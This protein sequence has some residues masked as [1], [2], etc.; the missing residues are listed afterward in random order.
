M[1]LRENI[2]NQNDFTLGLTKQLLQTECKQSNVVYSPLSIHV[3][4]SLIA[5]GSKGPTQNQLQ[6]FLKSNSTNHLNSF[7]AELVSVIFSDRSPSGGPQ[8][9]FVSGGWVD[10]CLHLKPYFKQVVETSYMAALAQVFPPR[11]ID[12]S[13]TLI[14]ANALYFKRAWTEKFNASQTKEHDFHL[15]D[16][17]I[18]KVPFMTSRK[19][20]YVR[21]FN[22]F[23]MHIF[24]REGKD[25]LPALV[26]KL[27]SESGFLDRHL[28]KQK[29]VVGDF[30]IPKFKISFGFKASNI[31]KGLSLVLPFRGGGGLT[32]MVDSPEGTG[33]KHSATSVSAGF[34]Q[35]KKCGNRLN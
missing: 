32:E 10:R 33:E 8:L 6:S 22:G 25:G 4:L 15:L 13:T 23:S 21:S 1:D 19:K 11:S 17:S 24:L 31:F 9:S 30:R 14:F 16:G 34:K 35:S 29:I 5:T 28:P 12:C 2:I 26:E 27:G 7:A 18:V 3:L 20:Q